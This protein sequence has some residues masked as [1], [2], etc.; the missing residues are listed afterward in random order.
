METPI[1]ELSE[2]S[3]NKFIK[4]AV[5]RAESM[6]ELYLFISRQYL[7]V[8]FRAT[9]QDGKLVTEIFHAVASMCEADFSHEEIVAIMHQVAAVIR[10]KLPEFYFPH[11]NWNHNAKPLTTIEKI[12]HSTPKCLTDGSHIN[13]NTES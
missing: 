13:V 4:K 7:P 9:K 6:K 5:A 10:V 3:L 2:E 8:L 12:I 11:V 1:T